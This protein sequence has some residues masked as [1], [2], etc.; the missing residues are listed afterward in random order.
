MVTRRK[1]LEKIRELKA[2]LKMCTGQSFQEYNRNLLYRAVKDIN[3]DDIVCRQIVML[4]T[5]VRKK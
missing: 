2:D 4:N 5:L 1:L 3:W